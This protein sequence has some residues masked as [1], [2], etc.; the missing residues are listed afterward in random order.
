MKTPADFEQFH[1][2][3]P[4]VYKCLVS[5]ARQWV[6]VTGRDKL[7]IGA[8]YERARWEFAMTTTDTDYKLNN[9][10]RAYYSRL[11]MRNEGLHGL[12]NLR[13]SKADGW[14]A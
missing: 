4:H 14:M 1:R 13:S 9:D 7:G 10:Y 5:L 6:T 8:L 3:N 2:Q 11:I 12:F